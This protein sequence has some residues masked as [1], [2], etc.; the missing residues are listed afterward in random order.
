MSVLRCEEGPMFS[1][2]VAPQSPLSSFLCFILPFQTLN[3]IRSSTMIPS[4]LSFFFLFHGSHLFLFFW[5]NHPIH[6]FC[7][8]VLIFFF[9]CTMLRCFRREL[10]RLCKRGVRHTPRV[11][12][13]T[14]FLFFIMIII[15]S[16]MKY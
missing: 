6:P 3:H 2:T 8:F 16:G 15:E 7:D 5:E 11:M 12:I 14:L 9:S 4:Y 13:L 1:R 10:S